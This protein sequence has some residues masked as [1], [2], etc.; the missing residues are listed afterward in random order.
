MTQVGRAL[1]GRDGDW[2][3]R[4]AGPGLP[5]KGHLLVLISTGTQVL[6]G[7]YCRLSAADTGRVN[8]IQ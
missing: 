8:V 4:V 1:S 5:T 6:Q 7:R 2:P 3:C